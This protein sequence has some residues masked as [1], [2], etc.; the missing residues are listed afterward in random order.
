MKNVHALF[1]GLALAPLAQA[2]DPEAGR[3][4][5]AAVCAACHGA[6]GVSVSDAIPNLGAQ[7]ARYIEAQLKA[8]KEG[9]RKNPL[10]NAIAA[11]LSAED[12]ANVAA[13]FA[14]Q[15]GAA[16]GA[17]SAFLPNLAKSRVNFPEGYQ[18]SFTKY[19]TINFPAT[20]QVRHYFAN[21]AAIQAAKQGKPLPDGAILLVE[22][23]AARLDADKQPVTG[24]DGFYETEKL[25]FYTAM[26]RGAGWGSEIPEMLRNGD[27][28]YALFSLDKQPLPGVNQAE[29]LACHK[30]LNKESY[31][32]TLK[33]L[34][35]AK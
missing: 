6:T 13:F 24:A 34:A 8:L 30:P 16:A 19:H 11:Q 17:R 10:M 9:T 32:F 1:V 28:N 22:V 5:V 33:P 25:L 31:V 18:A 26:A 7:R 14:A 12:I 27:W 20:R 35:A 23:Y 21:P 4:K 15:P 2:A 3:A 29:C